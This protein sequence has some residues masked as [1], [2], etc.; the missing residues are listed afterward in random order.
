MKSESEALD[1]IESLV[2]ELKAIERWDAAHWK[3]ACRDLGEIMAFQH[4]RMRRSEILSQ[5][6]RLLSA[7]EHPDKAHK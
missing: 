3:A 5:L 1:K 7:L 4:L 2:A 6:F